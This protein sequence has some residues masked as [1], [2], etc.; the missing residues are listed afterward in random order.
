[1]DTHTVAGLAMVLVMLG[2]ILA[3]YLAALHLVRL[4]ERLARDEAELRTIRARLQV[5]ENENSIVQRQQRAM[6]T[7]KT[8]LEKRVQNHTDELKRIEG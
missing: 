2:A 4:R 1:M 7:Q 8:R 3:K 6:S 5:V